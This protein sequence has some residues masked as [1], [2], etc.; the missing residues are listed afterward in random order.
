MTIIVQSHGGER[1]ARRREAADTVSPAALPPATGDVSVDGAADFGYLFPHSGNSDDYL[2]ED[3]VAELDQLGDLIADR[4]SNPPTPADPD[5]TEDSVLPPVLTYWGQF[6][7]HDLTARTDRDTALS[8]IHGDAPKASIDE[9]EKGL[10]NARTPLFDLDSVYGGAPVGPMPPEVARDMAIVIAG[11]RHPRWTNKMRV[12]TAHNNEPEKDGP[13]PDGLDPHRDLPRFS[14]ASKRVREAFLRLVKLQGT[15][16]EFKRIA[17]NLDQRALIGDMRNDENLIIAQ[18]HLSVLRFHNKA[19]DYLEQNDTGWMADFNSAKALTQLHY[20]WLIVDGY[21]KSVC[22]R[23]VVERVIDDRAKHFFAFR[24]AYDV[25]HPLATLGNAL[26]LE[27]SVAAFRFGHT[28][29]RNGYDY[30]KSFGRPGLQQP[31]AS[32]E[33]LFQFTGNGGFDGRPRLTQNMII[34]WSRFVRADPDKSDGVAAR[35]ARAIDTKLAPPLRTMLNEG[36]D[37]PDQTISDRLKHLARRNL[38]RGFSLRLPT[39]Q[40]LHRHLKSID[41]VNSGPIRN[42]A[43]VLSDKSDLSNF[44]ENSSAG[45]HERTPLWFYCLAEAEAAGGNHLGELGS[46]IVASTFVGTLLSDPNSALSTRFTP[47]Q[48]PLRAPDGSPID[49]IEKWM[50]FARVLE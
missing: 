21:L 49:S 27:F 13:L 37:T 40:A 3:V 25:R 43:A 17:A 26:P 1:Q 14:Q 48:S 39:G 22:D 15:M 36:N 2:P 11:L 33:R 50:K 8:D 16:E 30:N 24:D 23:A 45:L 19:V 29:V 18:F 32:F 10:K 4:V 31:D 42:V 46:W 20:Q 28:M 5:A 6:L 35:V 41:A 7:D 38:R 47:V 34:D 44:L 12:G 9:I